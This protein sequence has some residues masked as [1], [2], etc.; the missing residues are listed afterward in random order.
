MDE[1]IEQE[2]AL[3]VDSLSPKLYDRWGPALRELGLALA[4]TRQLE[5]EVQRVLE[6]QDRARERMQNALRLWRDAR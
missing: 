2:L 5:H 4:E 3:L 6:D 1:D